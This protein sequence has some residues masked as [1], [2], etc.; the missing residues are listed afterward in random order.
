MT[1]LT[2]QYSPKTLKVLF[3]LS[4]NQCAHPQCT[5]LV[6]ES[7]TEQSDD[8]V[9]AQICHIYAINTRGPRGN[10]GLTKEELNS[11][12]NLLLLC[13]THHTL[14]DGQHESYP[15]E[16]LRD[17]KRNHQSKIETL[18]SADLDSIRPDVFAHP[19]FPTALVD[20]K[21]E[22]EIDVL[23]KSQFYEEFDRVRFSLLL[24]RQVAETDLSGGTGEVRS[25]A[26]A[27]CARLLSLHGELTHA[28][29]HLQL[30]KTLGTSVEIDIAEAFCISRKGDMNGA[31]ESLAR[32]TSAVARSSTLMLVA[33]YNGA[34]EAI[35]WLEGADISPGDLDSIGK[36]V[37]LTLHLNLE[38][39]DTARNVLSSISEEDTTDVPPLHYIVAITHLLTTVPIDFRPTLREQ[40]PTASAGF[41]I[42]SDDAAMESRRTAHKHFLR[43]AQAAR[44]QKCPDAALL[45]DEYA[46]WLELRDSDTSEDGRRRLEDILRDPT[47]AIRF[48]PL[49]LEFGIKLDLALIEEAIDRVIALNGGVTHDTAIARLSL[50]FHQNSPDAVADYIEHHYGELS[51]YGDETAIRHLQFEMLADAG[52]AERAHRL[53]DHLIENGL[54][55]IQ[56]DRFQTI[57]SRV[58]GGDPIEIR[59]SQFHR[60]NSISD[61]AALVGDLEIEQRW[62]DFCE[63]GRTLFDLTQDLKDAGRLVVALTH[64]K[65]FE[66]IVE[67]IEEHPHLVAQSTQLRLYYAWALYFDGQLL[68]A[69]SEL[70]QLPNA[71]ED[72]NCRSLGVN[73]AI[74]LGDWNS[75]LSYVD[76]E[77]QHRFAKGAHEL[78]DAAKL[79]LHMGSLHAKELILLAAEKGYN[80]ADILTTAYGLASRAGWEDE[81][82]VGEWL[83]KAA[84][85]STDQGPLHRI[86]VTELLTRKPEW[87]RRA[88]DTWRLLVDG[89]IPMFAA[90][91]SLN[92]SLCDLML[93]PALT[94]LQSVDP[95][96]RTGIPAYSGM[97]RSLAMDIGKSSI[98]MDPTALLTLGIL[99]LLEKVLDTIDTIW[100]PHSTLG[101]LFEEKQK[102]TFHQPSR[103]GDA[104]RLRDLLATNTIETFGSSTS[105][106]SD[107][108][109]QVG[110]GLA[111]LI[112]EAETDSDT[113]DTQRLVV[114]PYPVP[115]LSS[116]MEEDAD[117]TAHAAVMT[118]CLSVVEKLRTTGRITKQE[119]QR[120]GAYLALQEEPWPN[121]P[122]I[123]DEAILYLDDVAVTYFLHLG[124]L[125]KLRPAGLRPIVS[126]RVVSEVNALIAY[127]SISGQVTDIIERIRSAVSVRIKSGKVK[128]GKSN[129]VERSER[130]VRLSHP[131]IELTTMVP[132]CDVIVCD[133]RSINRHST[134]IDGGAVVPLLTTLDILKSLASS[135]AISK[136]EASEYNTVLRQAG[137]I[138]IPV[139]DAEICEYLDA[140]AVENGQLR[141]TAE[142][143]AVRESIL[144]VR[145]SEWL[146]LPAES[147]WLEMTLDA[148]AKGL[149]NLWGD[150]SDSSILTSRSDWIA[151]QID[152]RGWAHR[153]GLEEGDAMIA[154]G[155]GRYLLI[156]LAP[157]SDASLEMRDAYWKWAEERI[158]LP[159][160]EQFPDLYASIVQC[161]KTWI[162][163]MA[164]VEL[165]EGEDT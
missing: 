55:E 78:I 19:Y 10:P 56:R 123:S 29:E 32:I 44:Y 36:Y 9:S 74:T 14:V 15:V 97:R 46:L 107:L 136:V 59:K 127:E 68:K 6:I 84:E 164:E 71:I 119:E 76:S 85:L 135:G 5:N 64:T 149:K 100:I 45:S 79:A 63:Y 143:K 66:E 126:P 138:F 117:L 88:S 124:C 24:G 146:Q 105:V 112:T 17:W 161:Q 115:R 130:Q 82:R 114:R 113:D 90:A 102:A 118:S 103:I 40:L 22:Y 69:T 37:L 25:R 3:A 158:L 139:T 30:A 41:P 159:I 165:T 109:V 53:L 92:Q 125:E 155:R 86:T 93:F 35:A 26:L 16:V 162:G 67:F 28:E 137:Y 7:A 142:L 60:T 95:R 81:A 52:L 89:A 121:Q 106:D 47:S 77:Y 43:A 54:S 83:A 132:E 151:A 21:I 65:R 120:A 42:A 20:Q 156:L 39:W 148:F 91:H 110:D 61:L 131:T 157:P 144:G 13:P 11:P 51:K 27:W 75:L 38:Q 49:G 57:I 152:I 128:V 33:H 140:S 80:D 141:E 133:D 163:Q 116:L 104:H 48:I 8:L 108:A 12:G 18:L 94:N 122:T 129:S 72:P 99:D 147:P 31:L 23:R 154:I 150:G 160:Q 153:F 34:Q 111:A 58:E 145:M 4:G 2:R 50:A 101:W 73:L 87:D 134:L 62:D 98:G 70:Q 1:K 96:R